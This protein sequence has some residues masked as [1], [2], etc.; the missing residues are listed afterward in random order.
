MHTSVF[1]DWRNHSGGDKEGIIVS[2]PAEEDEA[3][4]TNDDIKD[5]LLHIMTIV[6]VVIGSIVA[7]ST[8]MS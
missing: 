5:S 6:G 8:M 2:N 3:A 1:G 4:G 7:F